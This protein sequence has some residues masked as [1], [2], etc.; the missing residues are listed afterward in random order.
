MSHQYDN[1]PGVHPFLQA[2]IGFVLMLVSTVAPA[3]VEGRVSGAV[4]DYFQIGAWCCTCG[5]FV[6]ALLNYFGLKLN[7]FKKKN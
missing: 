6:I 1:I 3:L 2:T 7:P 5:M 4:M